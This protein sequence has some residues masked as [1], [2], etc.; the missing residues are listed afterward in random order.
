[1]P[2][3]YTIDAVSLWILSGLG[4]LLLLVAGWVAR[5]FWKRQDQQDKRMDRDRAEVLDL[6]KQS[7]KRREEAFRA[8]T[9]QFE[10]L[11]KKLDRNDKKSEE[12]HRET[13]SRLYDLTYLVGRLVGTPGVQDEPAVRSGQPSPQRNNNPSSPSDRGPD[14]A[15]VAERHARSMVPLAGVRP[16]PTVPAGLAGQAVPGQRQTTQLDGETESEPPAE[17][18]P[19][20]AP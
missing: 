2:D 7:A 14:P 11:D 15:R 10:K 20:T 12:R 8:T 1:M 13:Q 4:G 16:E 19:D 9:A 5:A 18:S 3:N 6:I 17:E